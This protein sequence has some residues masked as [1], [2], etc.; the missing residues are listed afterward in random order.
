MVTVLGYILLFGSMF[1]LPLWFLIKN[2]RNA[3]ADT[4]IYN[5]ARIKFD[6]ECDRLGIRADLNFSD[7]YTSS[8]I[9]CD[10]ETERIAVYAGKT[11]R[12]AIIPYRDYFMVTD[13]MVAAGTISSG[14]SHYVT[15]N[16]GRTSVATEYKS[17]PQNTIMIAGYKPEIF[18]RYS[19]KSQGSEFVFD[20]TGDIGY[21]RAKETKR[22]CNEAHAAMVPIRDYSHEITAGYEYH[23]Y[24]KNNPAPSFLEWREEQRKYELAK[25]NKPDQYNSHPI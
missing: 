1:G 17:S 13:S 4:Q 14:S 16:I 18:V 21:R 9:R 25:R 3:R 5:A 6:Q 19:S 15:T 12:F 7:V 22:F 20:C 23:K 8:F 10:D 24:N 11:N 2:W